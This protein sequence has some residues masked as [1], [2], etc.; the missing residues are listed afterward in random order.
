MV[1]SIAVLGVIFYKVCGTVVVSNGAVA[2]LRCKVLICRLAEHDLAMIRNAV[3]HRS[4]VF[5]LG[6]IIPVLMLRRQCYL[7]PLSSS[8]LLLPSFSSLHPQQSRFDKYTI[9]Y[10]RIQQLQ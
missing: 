3:G 8:H 10:H 1:F 2:G 5:W 6:Q 4:R 7:L 9:Q